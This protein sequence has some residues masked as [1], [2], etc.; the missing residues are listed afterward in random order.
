MAV[1]LRAGLLPRLLAL[2]SAASG[3][4][5]EFSFPWSGVLENIAYVI[6]DRYRILGEVRTFTTQG[7]MSGIILGLLPVLMA[8]VLSILSPGYLE[9]MTGDQ[10]GSVLISVAV[11]LQVV[12]FFWIRKVV[13]IKI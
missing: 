11:V 9:H 13:N 7:R 10:L 2:T 4:A 12:G 5:T 3:G 1:G 6:R 8:G